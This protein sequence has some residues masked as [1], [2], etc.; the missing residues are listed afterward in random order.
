MAF[1]GGNGVENSILYHLKSAT[2][3]ILWPGI[4]LS[5]ATAPPDKKQNP[6]VLASGRQHP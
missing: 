5:S 1:G 4:A 3:P 2:Y 6:Y